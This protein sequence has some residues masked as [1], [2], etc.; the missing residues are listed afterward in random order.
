[1]NTQDAGSAFDSAVHWT[2]KQRLPL[3]SPLKHRSALKDENLTDLPE[4]ASFKK[5]AGHQSNNLSLA[6]TLESASPGPY[7]IRRSF[8]E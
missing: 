5:V 1:M 7:W 6:P 4:R 8:L 3:E 2:K